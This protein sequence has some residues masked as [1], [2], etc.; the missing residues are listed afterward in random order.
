MEER[1]P[2]R[3]EGAVCVDRTKSEDG[4]VTVPEKNDRVTPERTVCPLRMLS[5][6]LSQTG[7][8]GYRS[9]S[10]CERA[11]VPALVPA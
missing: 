3:N 4:H 10:G 1:S 6:P 7:K 5:L 8:C 9:L 11:V 2:S